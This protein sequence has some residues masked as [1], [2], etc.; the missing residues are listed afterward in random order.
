M[1]PA[2]IFVIMCTFGLDLAFEKSVWV[3]LS[4]IL[5]CIVFLSLKK[6]ALKKI[7]LALLWSAPLVLGTG[8]SQY[9][10]ARQDNWHAALIY[11]SRAEAYLFLA[12]I[13]LLPYTLEKILANLRD[14]LHLPEH[15]MYGL[16]AALN[17]A[18]HIRAEWR[19]IRYAFLLKHKSASVLNPKLYVKIIVYA[20]SLA[21][22]LAQAMTAQ[23]FDALNAR[24][25]VQ[26]DYLPKRQWLLAGLIFLLLI[27][28]N[29]LNLW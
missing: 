23:G 5:G 17:M 18:G 25:H 1:N 26:Y 21:D 2:V 16:L 28:S 4:I 9:L 20:L 3:N 10:Y 13:L 11:A 24:T 29:F 7:M 15:F 27:G 8:W 14:H 22:D 6:A 12:L 19:R